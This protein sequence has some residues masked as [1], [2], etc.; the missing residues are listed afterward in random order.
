MPIEVRKHTPEEEAQMKSW[1]T[2]EKEP[3]EFPWHYG[4]PETCLIL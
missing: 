4:E 2:W 1:P 3:S